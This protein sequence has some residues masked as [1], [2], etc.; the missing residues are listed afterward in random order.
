[1]KTNTLIETTIAMTLAIASCSVADASPLLGPTGDTFAVLSAA[2]ITSSG[3]TT[4]TG[5][6][7]SS[8]TGTITGVPPAVITGGGVT[9]LPVAFQAQGDAL[10]AYNFLAI[11]TPTLD[12]TGTDLGGLVLTPGV[13]S[14]SSSAQLTGT[15][16]LNSTGYDNAVFIFETG[17]TL[18]TSS[19][20]VVAMANGGA[21]D[22]VFWR[23]GSSATLGDN[24][25]FIGNILANTSIT[26][27]PF[28]QISCGRA[29]AG[30]NAVS[31]AVTMADGNHVASS[32]AGCVDGYGGGY[33]STANGGFRL[34]GEQISVPE[35]GTLAMLG[36]GVV[37]LGFVR[38][39]HT[40]TDAR[41]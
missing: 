27:D 21:H 36:L 24:T 33:E 7:G 12:L 26:L 17:S 37:G 32:G 1:M 3:M 4:I 2:G 8:P 38:R 25:L 41:T 28:A 18:T 30:I 16:T 15:L 20:A 31:G 9:S 11:Q 23:V 40:A 14:F 19:N 13:Y 29:M 6:V 34:V 10:T 39:R 22:G 35:P 5:N